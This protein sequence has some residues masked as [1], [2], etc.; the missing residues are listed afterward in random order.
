MA[1]Q[2][3]AIAAAGPPIPG[4][5]SNVATLKRDSVPT[6]LNQTNIAPGY[7][8]YASEQDRDLGGV[9]NDIGKIL[10]EL[11]KQLKPRNTIQA[12]G[13]IQIM[14]DCFRDLGIGLLFASVLLYF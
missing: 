3:A 7:D 5:L 6:N 11:Q 1:R 14:H 12:V 2:S 4:L 13:Q 9:P 8:I 10:A